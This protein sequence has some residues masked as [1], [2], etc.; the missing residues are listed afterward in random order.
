[1]AADVVA[2]AVFEPKLNDAAGV[3]VEATVFAAKANGAAAVV[4][5]GAAV[6]P[7]WKLN[8]KGARV[9]VVVAA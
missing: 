9:V 7:A 2:L 1:M 6:F 5:A 8:G 4:L 3:V